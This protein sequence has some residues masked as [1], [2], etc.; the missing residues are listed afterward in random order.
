[1]VGPEDVREE[2]VRMGK[3]RMLVDATTYRLRYGSLSREEALIMIDH[4]RDEILHLCPD[5]DDVFDLVLRPRFM[6][7]LD[8]R[9]LAMW[10]V[11]DA[12]N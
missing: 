2:Q 5:K 10:G 9:D 8:E 4:V 6:R 1:M 7:F 11:L 12:M 3:V